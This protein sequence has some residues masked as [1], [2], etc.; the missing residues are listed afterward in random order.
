MLKGTI[1]NFFNNHKLFLFLV[2]ILYVVAI[3]Y[4]YYSYDSG[5]YQMT[6]IYNGRSELEATD[7]SLGFYYSVQMAGISLWVP[8]IMLFLIPN[9]YAATNAKSLVNKM[10]YHIKTRLG[11]K[12]YI[13]KTFLANT[14]I[15]CLIYLL[16]QIIL[17]FVIYILMGKFAFGLSSDIESNLNILSDNYFYNFV[18]YLLY[19]MIG[20]VVF[21]NFI[22]AVSLRIKNQ[23]IIRGLGLILGIALTVIPAIIFVSLYN[24]T[25]LKLFLNLGS[26]IFARCILMPGNFLESG[27]IFNSIHITYWYGI[28]FY[29]F[30]T[31]LILLFSWR[32][33]YKYE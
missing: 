28:I 1:K 13:I 16:F 2:I 24:F 7:L 22:L 15:S 17:I 10:N 20:Y 26:F 6:Q 21:S 4:T 29:L 5:Y 14:V 3:I 11:F 32:K 30:I 12:Q 31:F 33:E 9:L 18:F 8:L 27:V 19:S 23:Y 25:N